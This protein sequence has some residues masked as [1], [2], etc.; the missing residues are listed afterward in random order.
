[1][2]LLE[3]IIEVIAPI[4]YA[5]LTFFAISAWFNLREQRRDI[6]RLQFEQVRIFAMISAVKLQ[7]DFDQLLQ[8]KNKMADYLER[9]QYEKA[10]HLKELIAQQEEQTRIALKLFNERFGDIAGVSVEK[11][12]L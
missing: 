4:S 6:R 2:E 12:E 11:V 8:M 9:E 3:L 1:M 7:G 10:Q 5:V